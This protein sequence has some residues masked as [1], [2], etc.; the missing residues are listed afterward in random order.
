MLQRRRDG[1]RSAGEKLAGSEVWDGGGGQTD[2]P[3]RHQAGVGAVARMLAIRTYHTRGLA[4]AFI[5]TLGAA[6]ARRGKRGTVHF[7][8][9]PA[10]AAMPRQLSAGTLRGEI[11]D[12]R[13]RPLPRK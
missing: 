6:A 2:K 3:S 7:V 4:C 11:A 9:L 12:A 8:N 13:R 1:R 5:R 10:Q